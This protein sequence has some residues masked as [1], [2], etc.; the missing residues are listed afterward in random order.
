MKPRNLS[1]NTFEQKRI[2]QVLNKLFHFFFFISFCLKKNVFFIFYLVNFRRQNFHVQIKKLGSLSWPDFSLWVT[3]PYID[4]F[5]LNRFQNGV[6]Y[7]NCVLKNRARLLLSKRVQ[8]LLA[9]YKLKNNN[10]HKIIK[11]T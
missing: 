10:K 8:Q 4:G 6:G 11:N 1:Q 7:N 9:L 5:V 2:N 3:R